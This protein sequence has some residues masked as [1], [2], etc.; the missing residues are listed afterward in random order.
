MLRHPNLLGPILIHQRKQ[1][2]NYHY[3]TSILVGCRPEMR[4]L[5]AF[6]TDGEKALVLTCHSQFPDAIHLRCWLHFKDN[7][8]SKLERG[9]HLPRNVTQEFIADI[10]GSIST[11]EHGLVDAEDDQVFTT[12]LHSLKDVWNNRERACTKEDPVFYN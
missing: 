6:G 5:H 9:L 4:Q 10:M 8:L 1:F 12:Q 3:F 2:A 7:L 11:L